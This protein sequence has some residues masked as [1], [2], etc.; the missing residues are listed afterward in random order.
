MDEHEE[1]IEILSKKLLEVSKL[2]DTSYNIMQNLKIW[3]DTG[4]IK[5][6]DNTAEVIKTW[7]ETYNV[8]AETA[9]IEENKPTIH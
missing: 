9:L 2:A 5:F 8:I 4:K 7:I 1:K 3:N 6:T